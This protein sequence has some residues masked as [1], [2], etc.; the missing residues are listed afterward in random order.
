MYKG[1][2]LRNSAQEYHSITR[3]ILHL[4][5]I[6][7]SAKIHVIILNPKEDPPEEFFGSPKPVASKM[8]R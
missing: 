1:L 4:K 2:Y 6:L 3:K 8:P 7:K 5:K